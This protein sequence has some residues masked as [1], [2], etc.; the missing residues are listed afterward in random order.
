MPLIIVVFLVIMIAGIYLALPG[1][2]L[3]KQFV[4]EV[5]AS[6]RKTANLSQKS[7]ITA[8][9]IAGLPLPLQKHISYCG[10]VGKP[11]MDVMKVDFKNALFQ[12][13]PKRNRGLIKIEQYNTC[14]QPDRLAFVS[15]KQFI[16]TFSGKDTLIDGKGSMTIKMA[17]HIAFSSYD[18]PDV[19][20]T[21]LAAVLADAVAMPSLFL[22]EFVTCSPVDDTHVK[23]TI[24]WGE[25]T[26]SG[27]Y[28]FNEEGRIVQYDTDDRLMEDEEQTVNLP[29]TVEYRDYKE[30]DGIMFPSNIVVYWLMPD[31][32]K[33][34]QLICEN[35]K[36][37][38]RVL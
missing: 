9:S 15:A 35:L 5:Q 12:L 37:S 20:K 32:K 38:H 13:S 27:I 3:Y 29:W 19:G 4:E 7:S 24:T 1:D 26:A 33:Y 21:Q 10:Y 11:M 16:I 8:D 22:Q 6:I 36:I 25:L 23:C 2:K 17:K 31:E 30:R 14:S 28:T 34:I 18:G